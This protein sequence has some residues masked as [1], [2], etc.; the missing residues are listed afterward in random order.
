M[1]T[2]LCY[3]FVTTLNEIGSSSN[4]TRSFLST[5]S[6]DTSLDTLLISQG[7]SF[8]SDLRAIHLV[9]DLIRHPRVFTYYLLGKGPHRITTRHF[10]LNIYIGQFDYVNY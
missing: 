3:Y 2:S 5:Y 7:K 6:T 4:V 8:I 10:C 9:R 1:L